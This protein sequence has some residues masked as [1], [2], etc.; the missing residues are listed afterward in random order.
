MLQHAPIGAHIT[1][2]HAHSIDILFTSGK[3]AVA[4]TIHDITS[5]FNEKA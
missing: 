4:R 3:S 5:I 2:P 1:L